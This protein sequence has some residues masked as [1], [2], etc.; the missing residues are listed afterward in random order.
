MPDR[1]LTVD[2]HTCAG[3]LGIDEIP[4]PGE[5]ERIEHASNIIHISARKRH[6]S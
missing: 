6:S 5:D 2:E 3:V 1:K 4:G